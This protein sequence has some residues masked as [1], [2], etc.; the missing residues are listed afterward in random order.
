MK[1][2]L[3]ALSRE[4]FIDIFAHHVSWTC[5]DESRSISTPA[6]TLIAGATDLSIAVEAF[7][8]KS[9]AMPEMGCLSIS[10]CT[11]FG[12]GLVAKGDKVLMDRNHTLPREEIGQYGYFTEL[13]LVGDRKYR[14]REEYKKIADLKNAA[15]IMRRGDTVYGHWLLEI[16]P[17]LHLALQ[18][19]SKDMKYILSKEIPEYQIDIIQQLGVDRE[20]LI[21][22][23]RDEAV[24]CSRL[25]V[26]SV[27]H[28]NRQWLH[29]FANQVF[30]HLVQMNRNRTVGSDRIF[31]TRRSRHGDPRPLVNLTEIEAVATNNGFIVVDPGV[32]DWRTQASLF[33]Q[34]RVVMGLSGSGLHNTAFSRSNC[35][36]L[37]LQPNQSFNFL[38]TSIAAIRGH[39]VSYLFGEA[40][41]GFDTAIWDTPYVVDP[42]LLDTLIESGLLF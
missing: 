42:F 24:F 17:R 28:T 33:S 13:E 8:R 36:V 18:H 7:G 1:N 23:G 16:L 6:P 41:S 40:L 19:S 25:L 20:R 2:T 32:I 22:L 11:A 34:A 39:R 31:V 3:D 35:H 29:P 21:F 5:I 12:Y 14:P 15:L 9:F 37:V 30:D 4:Q 26:P 38:Q 10:D 27:P